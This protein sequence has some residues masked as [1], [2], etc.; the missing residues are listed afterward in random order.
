MISR[1]QGE[2]GIVFEY[3][4]ET[5]RV[6]ATQ[7]VLP[8]EHSF[9]REEL[10]AAFIQAA[11]A[12]PSGLSGEDVAAREVFQQHLRNLQAGKIQKISRD[13]LNQTV[14]EGSAQDK[15][16][17]AKA[18]GVS[19][20]TKYKRVADKVRPILGH[21]DERFRIVR[22]ITGDPLQ[23]LPTLPTNPGEFEPTG[24]YTLERKNDMDKMHPEGFLW[25]EE[26]KL[27]HQ[28]MML[29]NEGFA[30]TD[31]ERGSFRTDF[32]HPIEIPTVEHTPW[33]LKNMKIAPGLYDKVCQEV[34]RKLD[35]GVYEP[36]NS[37]YRS[38]W[39]CVLKKDGESLRIVHSLEPLNAVTIA[40]SGVPPAT[41]DL[42][43]KFAG[44]SCG[45]CLDL[46]VGYDERLLAPSSRDLTTFQTPYGAL[47]LVTLPMG[48][49]NSV[50]I[51]H[52]DVTFILQDEIPEVTWPFLD[53]VP[54]GG[55]RTRYET[56]D[57]G[58]ETIPENKGIRRF[59]W[60]Q[61]E[62]LNRVVQ[63]M[64][65]CGGTFS[66]KKSVLCAE[67]F[68]VVGHLCTYDGRKPI[69]DRVGVISRWGPCKE[70][71]DVRAFLGTIGTMRMFIKDFAKRASP[72]QKLTR[73]NEPFVWGPE[74]EEAMADLK[75]AIE[76]APCLRSIDYP[77]GGPVKLSVDTSWH[78]IGW[79]ISQQD[80]EDQKK[81][82]Y[83]RFGS[84]LMS[85]TESH[86][87]Q[88]KRELFGL[89]R[90]L[91]ENRYW[92]IGIRNLI[93]ET[94]A[95]YIKG[96]LNNP[97]EGPNATINRWIENILAFRFKLEHVAGKTFAADGLSRRPV[98]PDDPVQTP[99]DHEGEIR[100]GLQGY[101]KPNPDDPDPLD[102]EDFKHEIDSRGGYAQEVVPSTLENEFWEWLAEEQMFTEPVQQLVTVETLP[103]KDSLEVVEEVREYDKGRRSKQAKE[104]DA[105]I[106]KIKEWLKGSLKIPKGMDA[107]DAGKWVRECSHFYEK[108]GKLYR[109]Q[110]GYP[111]LVVPI[112]ERMYILRAIH[113]DLGHRG[114]WATHQ[115]VSK[116]FWWPDMEADVQ[117]YVKTC[118]LC[119]ERTKMLIRTP[120]PV[121]ETPSI[122]QVLHAD[123]M[124]MTPASNGCKY[125]VHGRC[126]LSSW[127][128]GK[129]IKDETGAQI[130]A[131]LFDI[132]TRWG[133]MREIVTDNGGVFEKATA[134]LEK[135]YGIKGIKI[136]PYNSRANGRVERPH[137]DVRDMLYKATK[138]KTS[139][140]YWYFPQIMWAD[141]V[142]VRKRF[143]VSPFFM[144]TG[145]EPVLPL[146]IQE[147]TWLVDP[148]SGP[149]TTEELIASR[150][151]ALAKHRDLVEEMRERVTAEKRKRVEQ[152]EREN[153]A[154][155]RDFD[156]RRGDLVLLRNTAIEKSLDKKMKARYLGPL[157]V[158]SRNKG[159]AYI[160]AEM[161]G[162][163]LQSPA[164]AFRVIPYHARKSIKLPSNIETFVDVRK[165][166]LEEMT[167]DD[168]DGIRED[169]IFRGMPKL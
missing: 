146:D 120:P 110:S 133:C 27:L 32:F 98:A 91:Q 121:T 13:Q 40:H 92:L 112:E 17:K 22:N 14:T 122:F 151:R 102:F 106:P 49:T 38:R 137:Y 167:N 78:A 99:Y 25:P 71:K 101:S 139:Q 125:I 57:G 46:Y 168:D 103:D 163:V 87:S 69:P 164:A 88:P 153:E 119:Q 165:E 47:R 83:C 152:Y 89:M 115:T 149:M 136:S 34:K 116:R 145:A 155:I 113:D 39:F 94:D 169:F 138:G 5:Q 154:T 104:F 126:A 28:F 157:V 140:W 50:P 117:W 19:T 35:A 160:L 12:D 147:A 134:W 93:V 135:K 58:Y 80:V 96:M 131:W 8:E 127:M 72:I 130:G 59:V 100:D 76:S 79:Y 105:K 65:Y 62:R 23:D 53:D 148:P 128:E 159:G 7:A 118:H 45:G 111:Q 21:L 86:Y 1:D 18:Q 156:F 161:D 56:E 37:S 30:W 3:D 64:K 143:G 10:Q 9:R 77:A 36:S 33:V 54:V 75:A 11:Y 60:E 166:T 109:R 141:R 90:A 51:F 67:E 144:V 6:N 52:D 123:V 132:I 16:A 84:T 81:W 31:E 124:H 66:G 97:E 129:A 42:A 26:R 55:P 41:E 68:V 162:S 85:K 2:V 20:G 142:T 150:A 95:K 70:V 29:H 158:I 15:K 114:A 73:A 48:W 74:Q 107:R 61:F 82:Y 24:R 108:E 63:R 44:R 43:A 4:P